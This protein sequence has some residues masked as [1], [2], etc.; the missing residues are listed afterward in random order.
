MTDINEDN[1]HGIKEVHLS[2]IDKRVDPMVIYRLRIDSAGVSYK[3]PGRT[4]S[5]AH[6][7][8]DPETSLNKILNK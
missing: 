3:G 5:W 7:N 2:C 6:L 4:K 8:P 1:Q